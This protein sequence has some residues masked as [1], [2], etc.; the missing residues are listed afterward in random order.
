MKPDQRPSAYYSRVSRFLDRRITWGLETKRMRVASA[1]VRR[2]SAKNLLLVAVGGCCSLGDGCAPEV[3]R[4]TV[5]D[6]VLV[7]S[8]RIDEVLLLCRVSRLRFA[9]SLRDSQRLHIRRTS[10]HPEVCF[11]SN[12]FI[13]S[14]SNDARSRG[15]SR[16]TNCRRS[17]TCKQRPRACFGDD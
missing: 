3:N 16:I 2:M 6:R 12:F 1:G 5:L 15:Y 17:E 14:S 9:R 4:R 8:G 13:V 11:V 7:R 10:H